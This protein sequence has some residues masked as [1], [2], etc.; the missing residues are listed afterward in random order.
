M[1]T[2]PKGYPLTMDH[3]GN[4]AW[5]R[6]WTWRRRSLKE[7]ISSVVVE[8]FRW[9]EEL[10]DCQMV[11]TY[12]LAQWWDLPNAALWSTRNVQYLQ[13][14]VSFACQQLQN[15]IVSIMPI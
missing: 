6:R 10:Y 9:L 8:S 12:H 4:N 7:V 15:Q 14:E 2:L 13:Q 11:S 3:L 1:P 5:T